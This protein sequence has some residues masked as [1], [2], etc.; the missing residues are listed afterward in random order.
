MNQIGVYNGVEIFWE[1]DDPGQFINATQMCKAA[2]KRWNDFAETQ[3]FQEYVSELSLKTGIPV[4]RLVESRPGRYGG[5]WVHRKVA[6]RLAQWCSAKFAVWVDDRIEE[7]MTTGKVAKHREHQEAELLATQVWETLDKIAKVQLNQSHGIMNLEQ[8]VDVLHSDVKDIK[9]Q[10]ATTRKE[11]ADKTK[12]EHVV[13]V[14][15]KYHGYCPCCNSEIVVDSNGRKTK[16]GEFDHW[17]L[18]S[19]NA[20]SETWLI[21]KP[22]NTALKDHA[23][24]RSMRDV[25]NAYQTRREQRILPLF[26]REGI[27][28]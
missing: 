25:F 21:C 12:H 26:P 17:E 8:K 2:G 27:S 16:N 24:R 13:T 14:H 19:K 22:C 5:T 23:F 1:G 28:R 20:P 9:E 4:I 7:L 3:E 6:I 18:R 11:L 10:W 15:E